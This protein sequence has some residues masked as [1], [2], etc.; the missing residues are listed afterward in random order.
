M[1]P[2]LNEQLRVSK[3]LSYGFVLS[4]LGVGG[5]A[6]M[7]AI[8]LGLKARRIIKQ[9]N[10]EISGIKMAWWCIIVGGLGTVL[11]PTIMIALLLNENL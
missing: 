5:I 4:I 1:S 11:L 7:I 8:V 9:S 6:S 2:D 3:M 10:S